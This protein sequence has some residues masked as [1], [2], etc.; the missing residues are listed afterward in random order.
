MNELE[1]LGI[2]ELDDVRVKVRQED[3]SLAR[4]SE[5]LAVVRIFC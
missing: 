2:I 3:G 1:S 4:I 5:L